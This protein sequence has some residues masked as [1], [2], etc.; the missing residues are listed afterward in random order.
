[1]DLPFN[2]RRHHIEP[3]QSIQLIRGDV[4][5]VI[6]SPWYRV[7]SRIVE[8]VKFDADR[9]NLR[10]VNTTGKGECSAARLGNALTYGCARE[11]PS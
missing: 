2:S 5:P 8:I 4:M 11:Y 9:L 6:V 3:E 1:M 7:P 10:V